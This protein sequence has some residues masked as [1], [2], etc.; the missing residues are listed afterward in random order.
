MHASR[1]LDIEKNR[2]DAG[3]CKKKSMN[4]S[5]KPC[6]EGRVMPKWQSLLKTFDPTFLLGLLVYFGERV[7]SCSFHLNKSQGC[8]SPHGLTN[9][10]YS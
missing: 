6:E 4:N 1:T 3:N 10:K 7:R 5:H 8:D 2:R 9:R